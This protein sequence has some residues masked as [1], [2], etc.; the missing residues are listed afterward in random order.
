VAQ[1]KEVAWVDD[2][3]GASAAAE[4]VRFALD[5]TEY[6]IDLSAE[7][8]RELRAELSP[9]TEMASR[10]RALGQRRHV[11]RGTRDD[12]PDVRAWAMARGHPVKAQG[13]VPR[14]II[15]EYDF[16]VGLAVIKPGA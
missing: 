6:E 14:R 7:H 4:Q 12:L 8:A 13:H 5:G 15:A 1:R 9:Y 10:R 11:R 3:D 2:L 16:L